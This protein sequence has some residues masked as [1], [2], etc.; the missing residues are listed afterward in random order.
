M[1]EEFPNHIAHA[2]A[3]KGTKPGKRDESNNERDHNSSPHQIPS[4]RDSTAKH[5]AQNHRDQAPTTMPPGHIEPKK[6]WRR[7]RSENRKKPTRKLPDRSRSNAHGGKQPRVRTAEDERRNTRN[8]PAVSIHTQDEETPPSGNQPNRT[9]GKI[10]TKCNPDSPHLRRQNEQK[11]PERKTK[12][13]LAN[14]GARSANQ[15]LTRV[16]TPQ[17]TPVKQRHGA[18]TQNDKPE[19]PQLALTTTTPAN[20]HPENVENGTEALP[21]VDENRKQHHQTDREHVL[22]NHVTHNESQHHRDT[23]ANLEHNIEIQ[24][25]HSCGRRH[26]THNRKPKLRDTKAPTGAHAHQTTTFDEPD[27]KE[28]NIAITARTPRGQH[29]THRQAAV[30]KPRDHTQEAPSGRRQP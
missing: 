12:V 6:S 17:H 7:Q 10:K 29:N 13:E 27:K 4:P 28:K 25:D 15:A 11:R 3:D 16:N 5:P 26:E 23:H 30:T 1:D 8:Q 21:H 19:N 22:H 9:D 24:N 2:E 14:A 18:L 20:H